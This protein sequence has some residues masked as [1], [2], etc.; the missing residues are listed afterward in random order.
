MGSK[1][2]ALRSC[3]FNPGKVTPPGGSLNG[4]QD[5][6]GECLLLVV[7]PESC[8]PS[9]KF[10]WA[11]STVACGRQVDI[12]AQVS[13]PLVAIRW[14]HCD[15]LTCSVL[16]DPLPLPHETGTVAS[17]QHQGCHFVQ[18]LTLV[19]SNSRRGF[20]YSCVCVIL[21]KVDENA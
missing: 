21:H 12:I 5:R 16:S 7:N 17:S 4:A 8:V 9:H 14:C 3:C 2:L 18:T 11:L 10:V 6:C 20:T 19:S 1:L 15:R 13:V